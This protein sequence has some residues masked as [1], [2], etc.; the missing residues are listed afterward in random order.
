MEP[1][2]AL[3]NEFKSLV[4]I[5]AEEEKMIAEQSRVR[6]ISKK[7]ML[8]HAGDVCSWHTFVTKGCLITYSI[9]N[10]IENILQVATEGWWVGDVAS[11]L[12]DEPSNLNIETLENSSIIQIEKPSFNYLLEKIPLLEKYFRI[13]LLKA[14]ASQQNRALSHTS[15][16]AEDRYRNF[17]NKYPSIELRIS[18]ARIASYLGVTP[19]FLSRMKSSFRRPK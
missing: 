2:A 9:S 8:L 5:T 17:I 18:Q 13:K 15:Q 4:N 12:S 16:T 11:F 3:I 6:A 7:K 19:E 1:I 14:L 10:D